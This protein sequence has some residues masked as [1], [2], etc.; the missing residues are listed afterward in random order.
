VDSDIKKLFKEMKISTLSILILIFSCEPPTNRIL[1]EFKVA[2]EKR[3][4]GDFAGA[5]K[6][7]NS[8]I[9]QDS[10]RGDFYFYRGYCL[11]QINKFEEAILDFNKSAG[12]GFN[13]FDCYFNLAS[14]Y[15]YEIPN[16]D[17]AN[18]YINK[19]ASINP[20][21]FIL[22]DLYDAFIEKFVNENS[23]SS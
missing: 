8:L 18:E 9:L 17:L 1:E 16:A 12:L 3:I 23:K 15:I 6:D 10:L 5:I 19:A 20:D 7:Y 21:P 2:N 14:I 13:E 22:I 4:L 11:V